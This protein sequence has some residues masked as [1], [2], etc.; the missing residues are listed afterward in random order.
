[1]CAILYAGTGA[2]AHQSWSAQSVAAAAQP[3]LD[4]F[5]QYTGLGKTGGTDL[6]IFRPSSTGEFAQFSIFVPSGFDLGLSRAV[7][8]KIGTLV[9]WEVAGTPHVGAITVDDPAKHT[10]DACALGAHLAIWMLAPSGTSPLPAYIDQTSGSET[11]LGGYKIVICVPSSATSGLTLDQFDIAP[12]LTNPSSSG[13][14]LWRVFVTPYLGGVP[15]PSGA[16]ELRSREPLPISLSL[17]GRYVRGRAVLTGQLVTPAASTAGI[18]INLYT[19]RSGHFNYTTYTQ[20]RSGG[21]YSFS[22]RIRKTTRFYAEVG[23]VRACQGE[24]VA[25]A[26]CISETM[27]SVSSSNVRVRVPKR[28]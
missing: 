22:R 2:A 20:T 15:N 3:S 14:Y 8:T 10:A 12:N 27:V 18:F 13:F 25:P 9:A 16:Y 19:E 26:G 7:G 11:A 28:R 24:T 17:R 6:E 21:R 23:S 1:V 5:A 4:V